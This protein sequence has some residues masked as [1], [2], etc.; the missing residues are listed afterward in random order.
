M[1]YKKSLSKTATVMLAI[2][3]ALFL[4]SVIQQ[5]RGFIL[6]LEFGGLS[7]FIVTNY[8]AVFVITIALLSISLN[9]LYSIRKEETPFNKKNVGKL[10]AIAIILVAKEILRVIAERVFNRF[11]PIILDDGSQIVVESIL[12]GIVITIGLV[13]YCIAL[14]FQYGI[15]LQDQVDETL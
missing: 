6:N 9:L 11:F 7:P 1:T 5:I 15:S 2:I 3:G 4:W 8:I 12:S 13:V 14:V 10:K